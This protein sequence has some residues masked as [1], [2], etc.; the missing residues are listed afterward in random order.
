MVA[1]GGDDAKNVA[2]AEIQ[3]EACREDL[4]LDPEAEEYDIALTTLGVKKKLQAMKDFGVDDETS[5]G[6]DNEHRLS[7][8]SS[9][10]QVCRGALPTNAQRV[11]PGTVDKDA[12]YASTRLLISWELP[13]RI[14]LPRSYSFNF[15]DVS[16]AFLHADLGEEAYARP[17]VK[18]YP[19]CGGVWRLCTAMHRLKTAPK[20]W[21][22]GSR[23]TSES[24]DHPG[25]VRLQA[26]KS[27]V[28]DMVDLCSSRAT[29]ATGTTSPRWEREDGTPHFDYDSHRLYRRIVG[30]LVW[31][32]PIRPDLGYIAKALGRSLQSPPSATTP[33]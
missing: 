6:G 31:L 1:P 13:L 33:I 10:K 18:F 12:T 14:G 3:H 22:L 21:Q 15:Y 23:S 8:A 27:Y 7:D 4:L 29:G 11:L 25:E 24:Y 5:T 28:F 19:N 26:P 2:H 20:P 16:L 30:K 32:V 9:T 17:L